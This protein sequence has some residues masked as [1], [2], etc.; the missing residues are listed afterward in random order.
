MNLTFDTKG[1][2]HLEEELKQIRDKD[3][4]YVAMTTINN[5]G[6]DTM[7]SMK[8]EISHVLNIKKRRVLNAFKVTKATKKKLIAKV[9]VKEDSWQHDVLSHHF[10][11]GDRKRKGLEFLMAYWGLISKNEI[12][13]PIIK[14]SSGQYNKIIAD[15]KISREL[16]YMA[17]KTKRSKRRNRGKHTYFFLPRERSFK[18]GIYKRKGKQVSLVMYIASQPNYVKSFDF[19]STLHEVAEDRTELHFKN[20]IQRAIGLNKKNGW[21]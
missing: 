13:I 10:S 5:L 3:I 14:L 12:L 20:S 21:N 1:L 9:F 4:P 6:F 19:E 18:P 15:L 11:G 8:D 17:N 2:K 16:G 7:D